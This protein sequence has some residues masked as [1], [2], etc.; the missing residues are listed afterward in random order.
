MEYTTQW[1]YIPYI[2]I[3]NMYYNY[4]CSKPLYNVYHYLTLENVLVQFEMIDFEIIKSVPT[5]SVVCVVR[6]KN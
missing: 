2:Y 3:N 4:Y 1:L 5:I 6:E